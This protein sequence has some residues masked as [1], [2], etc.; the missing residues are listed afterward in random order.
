MSYYYYCSCGMKTDSRALLEAHLSTVWPDWAVEHYEY[1]PKPQ[2]PQL[3]TQSPVDNPAE[4][5]VRFNAAIRA[6]NQYLLD[7]L[8]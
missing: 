7:H 6:V 2:I 3:P 1:F 4:Y 8:K 5:M